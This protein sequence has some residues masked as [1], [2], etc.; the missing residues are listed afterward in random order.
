MSD[1]ALMTLVRT[2]V[3]ADDTVAF[4]LL[5]ANPAL[6]KARFEIGATRQTAPQF[7]G[8]DGAITKLDAK[9]SHPEWVVFCWKE[10]IMRNFYR[11]PRGV[12]PEFYLGLP[13]PPQAHP[14]L[15][16]RRPGAPQPIC[17]CCGCA[18]ETPE[19]LHPRP[20]LGRKCK[21]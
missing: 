8:F 18:V 3:T 21:Q 13:I 5:A 16:R 14:L 6:A 2:I 19:T 9:H 1:A 10:R 12:D 15:P 7:S 11:T 17:D 20:R 4:H